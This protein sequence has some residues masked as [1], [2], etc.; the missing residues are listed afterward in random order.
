MQAD[1]FIST[2]HSHFLIEVAE[3]LKPAN[4]SQALNHKKFQANNGGNIDTKYV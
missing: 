3:K 4:K 2:L 1:F